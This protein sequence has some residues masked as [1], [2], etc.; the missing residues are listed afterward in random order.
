MFQK[1]QA[2]HQGLML[3]SLWEV[4]ELRPDRL[5]EAKLWG[6]LYVVILLKCNKGETLSDVHLRQMIW[7]QC[8]YGLV[9]QG[10]ER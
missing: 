9:A 1:K 7:R 4:V 8:E 5:E 10:N 6:A 2:L 3:G